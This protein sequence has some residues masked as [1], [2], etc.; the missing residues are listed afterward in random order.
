MDAI[1]RLFAYKWN[2]NFIRTIFKNDDMGTFSDV[3]YKR[4]DT[5][6]LTASNA[7]FVKFVC[8]IVLIIMANLSS[9]KDISSII[10]VIKNNFFFPVLYIIVGLIVPN[11][12][13]KTMK[14]NRFVKRYPR[15]YHKLLI[16]ILLAMIEL[17]MSLIYFIIGFNTNIIA[18]IIGLIANTVNFIAY[19]S[20]IT[21][22]IDFC[23][24][25]NRNNLVSKNQTKEVLGEYI[26]Y[27]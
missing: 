3:G 25:V 16:V 9:L 8:S 6:S 5:G 24:Y 27:F 14:N 21:G 20:I 7:F 17:I 23:I 11:V 15:T 26:E 1:K 10:E 12:I 18:S 13:S 19:L 2:G 22:I 4:V